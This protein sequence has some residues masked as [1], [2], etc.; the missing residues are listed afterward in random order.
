MSSVERLSSSLVWACPEVVEQLAEG[1]TSDALASIASVGLVL[2]ERFRM[3]GFC[4]MGGFTA[5]STAE[6]QRG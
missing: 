4:G 6:A 3:L 2:R 5:E 1:S